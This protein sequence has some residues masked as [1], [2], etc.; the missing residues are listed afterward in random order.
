MLACVTIRVSDPAESA[1]F[2]SEVLDREWDDLSIVPAEDDRAVTRHLHIA[3]AAPSQQA[4]DDFWQRGVDAG[5]RSDGEPGLRPQ[6]RPDYYG[7]FL[8][9][10]DGNSVESVHR[11]GRTETG[12]PI[13]HLWIGVSD[14]EASRRF[15]ERISPV[16]GLQVERTRFGGMV[17]VAGHR[18]HLMLVADGR[19]PTE[20]VHLA[21]AVADGEA[22][23]AFRR[24]ANGAVA[25]DP[26]GNA[27]EAVTRSHQPPARRS[28]LRSQHRANPRREEPY[29]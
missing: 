26:D 5:Y 19:P 7:G 25:L 17:V 15:W 16:I 22:L 23:A 13:D 11:P 14:L 1:R 27:V 24:V 6:Y 20:R 28:R 12:P 4:V 21:L 18:R 10:P 9:D 8:L 29:A 2:Y 3:F